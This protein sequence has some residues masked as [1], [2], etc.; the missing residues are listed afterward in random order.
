MSNGSK[1]LIII[2]TFL[3]LKTTG[4]K[5]H[6]IAL[7]RTIRASLNLIYPLT[8]DRMDMWEIGYKIPRAN[9]LKSSNLLSHGVFPFWMKNSITI[10][11]WLRKSSGYECRR[12]VIVM[13]LTKAVTTSNKLLRRR[14]SQRGGLN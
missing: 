7:K 2:T 12:R 8:S 3:L 1:S 5:T 4:N 6:L 14:I 9:L 11:S 10:R 13:R